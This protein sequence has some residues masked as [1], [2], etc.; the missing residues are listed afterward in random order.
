MQTDRIFRIAR[1]Y[2]LPPLPM[3]PAPAREISRIP[4]RREKND[5]RP[6]PEITRT[7][8]EKS[9]NRK[10]AS[11]KQKMK[12][13][14]ALRRSRRCEHPRFDRPIFPPEAELRLGGDV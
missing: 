8:H 10:V 6:R 1:S 4:R 7:R 14:C 2:S 9:V 3:T 13:A 12:I 11:V 5:M